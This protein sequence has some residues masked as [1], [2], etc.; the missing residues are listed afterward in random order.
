MSEKN[1]LVTGAN[2]QLGR[3]MQVIAAAYP[4][5]HFLFVTKED[6]PIDNAEAV[7]NYFNQQSQ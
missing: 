6:L 2:G 7:K 3:E 5:H 4:A 1:I